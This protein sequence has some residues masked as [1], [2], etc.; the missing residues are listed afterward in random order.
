MLNTEF[1]SNT[2]TDNKKSAYMKVNILGVDVCSASLDEVL[3]NLTAICQSSFKKPFTVATVNPEFI[4][5]AQRD[6][7]FK[8]ILNR[9]D[10]SL[11][12][13][14]G[15]KF[16]NAKI[17]IVPGRKLIEKLLTLGYRIFFLGGED[18]VAA[19]MA[20]KYGGG[21][22]PG[23]KDISRP[24]R[25]KEILDKI[26]EF[27]PDVLLVAYGA[28]K[29]EKWIWENKAKLKAKVI[30]GA[31]GTFD[32]LTGKSS[33]PP[34]WV[35]QIGLEWLWRLIHEPWRWRRQL[36]L[37]AFLFKVWFS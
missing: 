34:E 7:E 37:V 15:L 16:A 17:K 12:D 2:Q 36:S 18:D 20:K 8:R 1:K 31:G 21:S 11:A 29:Q 23:E 19:K 13:G 30:I 14:R 24:A 5:L 35:N 26:N 28:S 3:E 9:F 4:M 22:D 33:L 25:N 6:R 10:L 27:K 32:F